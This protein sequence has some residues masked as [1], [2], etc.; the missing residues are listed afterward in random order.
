VDSLQL[1]L[2]TMRGAIQTD[3]IIPCHDPSIG[4]SVGLLFRPP[5][6]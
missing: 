5:P 4:P 1:R 6:L 2:A 3:T